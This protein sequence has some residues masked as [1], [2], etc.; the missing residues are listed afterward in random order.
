MSSMHKKYEVQLAFLMDYL[1]RKVENHQHL[2]PKQIL[3]LAFM[4]LLLNENLLN[5]R[6][7]FLETDDDDD[8]KL[9]EIDDDTDDGDDSCQEFARHA[10]EV[11]DNPNSSGFLSITKGDRQS[12]RQSSSFHWTEMEVEQQKEEMENQLKLMQQQSNGNLAHINGDASFVP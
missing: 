5:K 4:D 6:S 10:Y 2:Q 8:C 1:K 3:Q 7:S 11:S 9:H 12:M